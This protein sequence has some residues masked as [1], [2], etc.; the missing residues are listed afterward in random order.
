[1]ILV[2]VDSKSRFN[3][4]KELKR[5][6]RL[7]GYSK[8]F[9]IEIMKEFLRTVQIIV[10]LSCKIVLFG[11]EFRIMVLLNRVIRGFAFTSRR[12]DERFEPQFR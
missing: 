10:P 2:I 3:G 11:K 6:E 4:S 8:F 9:W 1:M 12:D 5:F 7:V